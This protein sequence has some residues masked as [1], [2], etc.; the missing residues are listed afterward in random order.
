MTGVAI[1][2][3]FILLETNQFKAIEHACCRIYINN[4]FLKPGR[5]DMSRFVAQYIKYYFFDSHVIFTTE[6][7]RAQRVF[8]FSLIG[9]YRSKRNFSP[10][11]ARHATPTNSPK[12]SVMPM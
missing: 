4:E 2:Q 9:R 6:V 1:H 5:I 7:H 11:S 10:S 8:S 3:G 12:N